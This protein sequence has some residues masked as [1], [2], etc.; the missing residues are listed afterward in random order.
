MNLSMGLNNVCC[1]SRYT[2]ASVTSV[3]TGTKT[4]LEAR[5]EMKEHTLTSCEKRR[6]NEINQTRL[7]V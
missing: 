5:R 4:F 6:T 1:L 2:H 3:Q 7:S